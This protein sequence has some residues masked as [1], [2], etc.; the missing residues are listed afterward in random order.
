[1]SDIISFTEIIFVP[2]IF[3]FPFSSFITFIKSSYV[4]FAITKVAC[5]FDIF[6]AID[7][8]TVL[9]FSSIIGFILS[10]TA[11]TI[12]IAITSINKIFIIFLLFLSSVIFGNLI[13]CL[14]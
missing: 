10:N 2:I 9:H 12:V 1:M 5:S 3:I 7:F 13:L 4:Y 14:V 8:A 6:V 11:L